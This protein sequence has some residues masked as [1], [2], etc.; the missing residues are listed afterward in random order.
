M[1]WSSCWKPNL[2]V[3][4]LPCCHTTTSL[5]NTNDVLKLSS[6]DLVITT[7]RFFLCPNP[8][9]FFPK[10]L[11]GE[12]QISCLFPSDAR[13]C[14]TRISEKPRDLV[15]VPRN[16]KP[17]HDICYCFSRDI[18]VK[19]W[20]CECNPTLLEKTKCVVEFL[21]KIW[22]QIIG[23]LSQ[24]LITQGTSTQNWRGKSNDLIPR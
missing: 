13:N 22:L 15:K 16:L 14:P 18:P 1:Y 2:T 6:T 19:R 11:F 12:F 5:D 3:S 24:F 7:I 23:I 17:H 8:N 9:Q 20:P 4:Y 10:I 21:F